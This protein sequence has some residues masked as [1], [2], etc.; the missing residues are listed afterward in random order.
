GL[1]VYEAPSGAWDPM[2][3]RIDQAPFTDIR[4]RQAFRLLANRPRMVA[5]GIGGHGRV[6]NDVFSPFDLC[7]SG[8]G[9]PQRHY[10]PEKARS[11]LNAAGQDGLTIDLHT[12]D[13]DSG[14]VEV[15]QIFAQNAKA[16]GV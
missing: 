15:A 16:G 1:A 14:M 3:M 9:F 11:L 12:T 8:G 13:G 2:T 7:Y 6:A 4:V 5:Q 10:D